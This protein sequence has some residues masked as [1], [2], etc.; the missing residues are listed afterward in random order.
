MPTYSGYYDLR[1]TKIQDQ[2]YQN[3]DGLLHNIE[4]PAYIR[5]TEEGF[6]ERAVYY[7]N[8]KELSKQQWE[9]HPMV[10]AALVDKKLGD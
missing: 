7:I 2:W 9:I 8:G 1:H 6:V 5:Y 4:G 10:I 3:V